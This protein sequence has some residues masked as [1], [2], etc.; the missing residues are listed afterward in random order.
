VKCDYVW[1][2]TADW[3]SFPWSSEPPL[4][5]ESTDN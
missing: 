1:K 5:G 2:R 3:I 4:L